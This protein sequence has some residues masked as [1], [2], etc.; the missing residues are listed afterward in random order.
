MDVA[1]DDLT[2]IEEIFHP[3]VRKHGRE[4]FL[5]VMSI[6]L[7]GNAAK[8]LGEQ[9]QKHVSRQIA[10]ATAILVEGFNTNSSL[11]AGLKGWTPELMQEVD[12][13]IRLAFGAGGSRIQ[14]LH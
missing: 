4:V 11:L 8:L 7:A 13:D 10:T 9:A 2:G 1:S 12:K 6:G 5:F 14:L 3:V